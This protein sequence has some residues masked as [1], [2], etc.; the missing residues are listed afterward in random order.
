MEAKLVERAFFRGNKAVRRHQVRLRACPNL[1][2]VDA[3][4]SHQTTNHFS[5]GM[6][7]INKYALLE[8][9]VLCVQA[10]KPFCMTLDARTNRQWWFGTGPTALDWWIANKLIPWW[11]TG[12]LKNDREARK[13]AYRKPIIS[14]FLWWCLSNPK[15][16]RLHFQPFRYELNFCIYQLHFCLKG[17][18]LLFK[19]HSRTTTAIP[20]GLSDTLFQAFAVLRITKFYRRHFE[21]FYRNRIWVYTYLLQA[22]CSLKTCHFP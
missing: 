7:V 16:P 20:E 9:H 14:L 17:K 15:H 3:S 18:A 5:L 10:V 13:S 12:A 22:S 11:Q 2:S 8:R 6:A 19:E 4:S 21:T 1:H